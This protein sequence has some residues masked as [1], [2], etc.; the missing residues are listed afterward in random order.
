MISSLLLPLLMQSATP[1]GSPIDPVLRPS[2]VRPEVPASSPSPQPKNP[3]DIRFDQCVDRAADDPANGLLAANKWQL[4][5]GGYLAR[6]CLGFAYA[7]LE[8][9]TKAIPEFVQAAEAA[10]AAGDERAA[11]FWS[12]AGNAALAS[13]NDRV[14]LEYLKAALDQGTLDGLLKGEVHLDMARVYVALD[15]YDEAKKQFA[16]VHELV[17]QDPLGW[18]L[19]ATLARRMGDLVQAKSD[20]TTA[21][22]LVIAD[23]AIALE[24]GNI[25]YE[26]GDVANAKSNW[27]QALKFGPESSSAKA[28]SSYL[29]QLET[30]V[31]E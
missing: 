24:A 19:S 14:A 25:A 28:A 2:E 7:E 1:Y 11:N 9:W 16:L 10:Q 4:E 23:P 22:K 20:I 27:E 5:G 21:A 3:S 15:Q 6:N 13:G 30:S 17:P 29:A 12:Q 18:L 26:A 8:D 31:E